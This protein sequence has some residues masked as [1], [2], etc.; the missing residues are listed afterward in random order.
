MSL[1]AGT[2]LG[3]YEIIGALGAGGMGEVYRARD[4]RIGRE[5]A[6]KVLPA[7]VDADPERRRRFHQEAVATGALNHPNVLVVHDVGHEDG[8][9]YLVTELLRGMTLREALRGGPL[10]EPTAVGYA[11]AVL[12]GLAAAH[13]HGIVHRDLKPENI[14]IT[15]DGTPK[16]L[17]FGLAKISAGHPALSGTSVTSP[18]TAAGVLLGSVG[19]MAP[20]QITGEATD[21]RSDLFSMAVILYEMLT[22]TPPFQRETAIEVLSA[23]TAAAVV[24]PETIREPLRAVLARGLQKAP[25]RRFQSAADFAFALRLAT[26]PHEAVAGR[27]AGRIAPWLSAVVLALGL[28]AAVSA[29]WLRGPQPAAPAPRYQRVTFEPGA[30][31]SAR[32]V[33][34]SDTIVYAASWRG[35]PNR[36]YTTRAEFPASVA[37]PMPDADLLG[38]SPSGE[39]ALL[40]GNRWL[41][42]MELSSG[43]LARGTMAASVPRELQDHVTTADWLPDGGLAAVRDLGS[44][45][46]LEFPV[47]NGI[48]DTA[49]WISNLRVSRDGT[50]VAF[51]DH[52]FRS[53]DRGDFVIADRAGTLRRVWKDLSGTSGLAWGPDDRELWVA[54]PSGSVFAV[55]A[56]GSRRE[57]LRDPVGVR[58]LDVAAD[59]RILVA[60]TQKRIGI[61]G[62]LA[63][64]AAER[65]LTWFDY[66]VA[67]DLSADGRLLLFFEA[68]EMAPSNY[69]VGLRRAADAAP[70]RIGEGNATSL[71]ADGRWALVVDF[72]SRSRVRVLPTGAGEPRD[73]PTPGLN[74][75][76]AATWHPD[77][78]RVVLSAHEQGRGARIY[79][80]DANGGAV[81]PI[82]PEGTVYLWNAVS[83]DGANVAALDPERRLTV[84]PLD[85]GPARPVPGAQPD[86]RPVSWTSDGRSLFV[87]TPGVPARVWRVDVQ[88]GKRT[89]WRDLLPPDPTGVV[90]I[91]PVLVSPDGRSY[92]YTYGRFLSTLY[93]V[94][95]AK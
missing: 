15:E 1:P 5:V 67:R 69:Y 34:R 63:G 2:R 75:V 56:D 54:G 12:E 38:V 9:P 76:H 35:A 57:V 44:V 83:P 59:G 22:G 71:S 53:D 48:Y 40:L 33:P 43:M 77:G 62:R 61:G 94:T 7:D 41:Q 18:A 60:R 72:T 74:D 16:I 24:V 52:P 88:T 45:R 89:A 31:W 42:G 92:A 17:D 32:F 95:D 10:A 86:E 36:T 64:D 23:I 65:D 84:Y 29:L 6:I 90:R 78:R 46:R 55:T 39:L 20:E 66:S 25:A 70:V 26:S 58:L 50:R 21:P 37:L 4:S 30:V 79:V 13:G 3:A 87:L 47:G 82:G 19:Y 49:G 73:L 93:V 27:G 8:R 28:V 68:G 11:T 14:F 80:V 51:A 85:G 91:S 81:R